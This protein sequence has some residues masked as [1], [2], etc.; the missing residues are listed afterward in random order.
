M[1]RQ[2]RPDIVCVNFGLGGDRVDLPRAMAFGYLRSRRYGALN[3]GMG[4]G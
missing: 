2:H 3:T 4:A 1:A